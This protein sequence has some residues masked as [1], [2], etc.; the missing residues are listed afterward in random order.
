MNFFHED[1]KYGIV[2]E[3]GKEAPSFAVE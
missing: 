1:G 2:D 3:S